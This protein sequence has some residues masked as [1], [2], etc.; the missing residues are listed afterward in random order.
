ML[1]GSRL[2]SA[3]LSVNYRKISSSIRKFNLP[4]AKQLQIFQEVMVA[5]TTTQ[6]AR[7]AGCS[8]PT[9]SGTIKDLEQEL[10]LR[11]FRRAK[12]RLEPT[13]EAVA[14][15]R[16][17]EFALNGLK[18]VDQMAADLRE[19]NHGRI[20]I[21]SFPGIS[22]QLL[23]QLIT[24]FRVTRPLVTF[25]LWS[26]S[27]DTLREALHSHRFDLTIVEGA[28]TQMNFQRNLYT[29]TC[30]VALPVDHPLT[31]RSVLSPE[32]LRDESWAVLFAEHATTQQLAQA[33]EA[34]G[35]PMRIG[36]ECEYFVSAAH[37]VRDHGG[38]AI[39][40][41]ITM[42]SLSTDG[43]VFRS[44][45]PRIEYAISVLRDHNKADTM[46]ALQFWSLLDDTLRE[47]TMTK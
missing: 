11:L 35:I 41:P 44:F 20:T 32:D 6:A 29:F 5:G 34:A 28:P 46:P 16:E 39:C 27:S 37:Y 45:H 40:D 17:V 30:K 47:L 10:G 21:L 26:R 38:V 19:A 33:H 14:L 24:E 4:S 15:L 12:G 42:A 22:W 23:P 3:L 31:S 9:V 36:L 2:I 13:S 43:L 18:R 25:K 1:V 8:Q 7:Q